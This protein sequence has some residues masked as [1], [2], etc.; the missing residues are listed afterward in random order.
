MNLIWRAVYRFYRIMSWLIYWSQRRFTFAGWLVLAAFFV[1]ALG[2]LDMESLSVYQGYV[3]LLLLLVVGFVFSW[4]FRLRYSATRLL[5]RFGT[6]GQPF[7]YR[8]RLKNLTTRIQNDLTFLENP[9]DPR[10]TFQE[11]LARQLAEE[12]KVRSLRLSRPQQRYNPFRIAVVSTVSVPPIPP[13]EEV[14]IQVSVTPMRRGLLRLEGLTLA[15]TD[16]FGIFRAF[17]KFRLP[18]TMLI[19]PKRYPLPPIALPG[20]MKYQ[21]GGVALASNVGQS[22]EFVALREYRRGDPLRRIHWRS[23]ARTGKPIVREFE[24]EFFARHALVLDTFSDEPFSER[25]EEVSSV[26]ESFASGVSTQESLLDL[27]FVAARAYCFTV[28]RGGAL[29]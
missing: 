3:L 25:F 7:V 10:P 20:N 24:D 1:C 16:P 15:R 17:S 21:E 11:W 2:A 6:A 8:V 27:L 5:P 14:E 23:W 19:L 12:K 29:W 26:A 18:E 9:V 4:F 22:D 13:N 28:G